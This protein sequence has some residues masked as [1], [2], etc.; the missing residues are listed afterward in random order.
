MGMGR[1]LKLLG[2]VVLV[3]LVATVSA[4]LWR[5]Q[6]NAGKGADSGPS[7]ATATDAGTATDA[8][9]PQTSRTRPSAVTSGPGTVL[10]EPIVIGPCSL[11]AFEEQEVSA[12]AEGLLLSIV[13]SL[14]QKVDRDEV[15]ARL[16]DRLL[17]PQVELLR[18][19]A[20]S[21]SAKTIARALLGEAEIKAKIAQDLGDQKAIARM[22]Y[23]NIR[24]QHERFKGEMKK[25]EEDQEIARKELAR[26]LC[27]LD[28]YEI[29]SGI[30]GEVTRI[31]K[32]EG[33]TVRPSEPLFYVANFDRLL[34]EGLCK[35]Q[36]AHLLRAGMQAVVEPEARGEQLTELRGHTGAITGL[37]VSPDGRLIAS[38]AEDRTVALWL[39]PEARRHT[40]LNQP[41]EVYAVAFDPGKDGATGYRLLTGGGDGRATLWSLSAEG[42]PCGS[43]ELPV[44]HEGAIRAVAFSADGRRCATGGEDRR[45]AIWDCSQ[46]KL[47][48][49]LKAQEETACAHQGAVTSVHF[50]PDGYLVSAGRDN[51]LK[52][53]K[54]AERGADLVGTQP[55]RSGEVAQPGVSADG[56][57]VLFE[58]GEELRILD[59]NDGSSLGL[60]RGQRQGRFQG[61]ALFS[62]SGRLVLTGASNG[63]LQLWKAPADLEAARF[64]RTG[65][66]RGFGP[67]SLFALAALGQSVAPGHAV[68]AR[69]SVP[70]LTDA[71]SAGPARQPAAD[72]VPRLWDLGGQEIRHYLPPGAAASSCAAF[73]PDETVFFSAGSDK[74]IRAWQAP[75]ADEVK[76]V[77]EAEIVYVGNQVERGTDMVRVRAELHNPSGHERRL[78]PG[79]FVNLRLYPETT[80]DK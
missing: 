66:A 59:R 41:V 68:V 58:H 71:G 24:S 38:S 47:L 67:H 30:G 35:V 18:I 31:L 75:S 28:E 43:T 44:E 72:L 78:K 3:A 49:W 27:L 34:V 46:G 29:R 7:Q 76:G 53:W 65:S 54:L 57:R 16:D 52:V 51:L 22:E 21:E 32:H 6:L 23:E 1:S 74:V 12:Q 17:R 80:T 63:R 69:V 2:S 26:T 10:H 48:Y 8:W 11:A 33:E 37:A 79:T 45:I 19:K 50:T 20:A 73:A 77:L 36:E 62:P 40:V 9:T 61:L 55:G 14:G 13:A 56:H 5:A 64:F 60:L 39:W 15:L 70:P 4:A 42:Y 25:A